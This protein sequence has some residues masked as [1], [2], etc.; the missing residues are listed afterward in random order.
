MTRFRVIYSILDR[1]HTEDA[2][3]RPGQN[4]R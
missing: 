4:W 1:E 3:G 2:G